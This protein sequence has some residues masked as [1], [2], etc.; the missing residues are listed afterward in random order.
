MCEPTQT[1]INRTRRFAYIALVTAAAMGGALSIPLAGFDNRVAER[2]VEGLLGLAE[3][4][5]IVYVGASVT[6]RSGLLGKLGDAM[7][8]R[9]KPKQE[10]VG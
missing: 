3:I 4:V 9:N 8:S 6:D 5:V 2:A 1:P 10:T 7:A